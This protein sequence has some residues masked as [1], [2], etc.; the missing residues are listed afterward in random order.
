MEDAAF[1]RESNDSLGMYENKKYNKK[2]MYESQ[3]KFSLEIKTH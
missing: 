1:K 2:G 3:S